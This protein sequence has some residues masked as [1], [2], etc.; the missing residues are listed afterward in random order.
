[1]TAARVTV[2]GAGLLADPSGAVMWPEQSLLIVA[3][4]HL[5][6]GSSFAARGRFLPPYDTAAT[7]AR[8]A[9]VLRRYRP[10]RVVCLGDSFHDRGA[11]GR[12]AAGDRDALNHLVAAH[13]WTWILGNH[14][15]EVPAAVA[16][17]RQAVL[18]GGALVLRHQPDGRLGAGELCGHFHPKASVVTAAR[19]FTGP[20]FVTDGTRMILP[21]FGAY[22]GGLDVFDPAIG[23]QFGRAGFRVFFL[24]PDR[25]H[26]F[27]HGR[28][29]RPAAAPAP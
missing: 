28:L 24:R 8:L 20:C 5:E 22:A 19:R 15:P 29:E 17:S 18:D 25:L 11:G 4:L 7:L 10:R 23:G 3:D 26:M 16:G 2:N 14:D 27:P 13:E 6:K 12:I 9:A 21:A 1:V